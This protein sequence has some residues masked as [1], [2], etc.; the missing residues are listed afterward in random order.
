MIVEYIRYRI[1]GADA[2]GFEAA[3]AGAAAS[4][5]AAPQCVD[6]ELSRCVDEPEWYVLR[7]TWTSAA[8]H[9]QEFR[10]GEHF[11]A[12][13]AEI[14]PYVDRIEEMRHYEWTAV[15]GLG[16]SVPTMYEWA[17]GEEAFQR[18]TEVFYGHV[19]KDDLIGP[20]FAHMDK[21][22]PRYVAMW[23]AE[24]FGGPERYSAERGGYHHMVRQH[25][26]KAISEPQRRRWVNLLMDAADDVGLPDDPEFRAAFASYIEWGTRIAHTNSQPDATPPLEAPMPHWG[27]GVAPPYIPS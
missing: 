18:L 24:V 25:L 12:F 17:G 26:G 19:L 4:L 13:F 21:D 3:Y 15:R 6:Y 14:R 22:H 11:A 23:L 5:A 10:S 7:I 16:G 2:D 27:W 20:L 1:A 8:A 9:L